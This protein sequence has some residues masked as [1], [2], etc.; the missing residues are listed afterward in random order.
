MSNRRVVML[1]IDAEDPK[2]AAEILRALAVRVERGDRFETTMFERT[3]AACREGNENACGEMA[4][5]GRFFAVG[6][7]SEDMRPPAA[8]FVHEKDAEAYANGGVYENEDDRPMI[9]GVI[10]RADVVGLEWNSFEDDSVGDKISAF[11]P[12]AFL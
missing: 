6:Y 11:A 12:R 8:L 10:V 2:T 5:V 9:G 7:D 4:F 1:G 3:A